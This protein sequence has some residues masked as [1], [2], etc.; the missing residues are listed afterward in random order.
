M[1]ERTWASHPKKLSTAF[2]DAGGEAVFPA[3]RLAPRAGRDILGGFIGGAAGKQ[4]SA[5]EDEEQ[6]EN[7]AHKF[8][9]RVFLGASGN[10]KSPSITSLS[11]Q[12]GMMLAM[13][14]SG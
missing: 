1:M 9:Y 3:A 14:R 8:P 2:V 11:F 7:E 12:P 6:G 5:Q 10:A 13:Q 4:E